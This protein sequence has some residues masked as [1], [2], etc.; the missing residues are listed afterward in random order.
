VKYS[1][2]ISDAVQISYA[3]DDIEYIEIS[4]SYEKLEGAGIVGVVFSAL[5][6]FVV[7][8]LVSINYQEGSFNSNTYR[9]WALAG[10]AGMAVSFP[11]IIF[12]NKTKRY[13]INGCWPGGG[14]KKWT[15]RR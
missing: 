12:S 1:D 7:A 10:T 6:T 14:N 11:F 9:N 8:P 13:K 2:T 15:T 5:T 4:R 3:I